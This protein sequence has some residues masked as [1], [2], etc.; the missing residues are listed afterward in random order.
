MAR[1]RM[2]EAIRFLGVMA[3]EAVFWMDRFVLITLVVPARNC[4]FWEFDGSARNLFN[5]FTNALIR[6]GIRRQTFEQRRMI[7]MKTTLQ[8]AV[9]VSACFVLCQCATGGDP[10]QERVDEI[11][12]TIEEELPGLGPGPEW[13][14]DPYRGT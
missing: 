7:A 6:G 8:I 5:E 3:D 10:V 13:E 4:R 1:L 11:G 12:K 2:A 9:M 14:N